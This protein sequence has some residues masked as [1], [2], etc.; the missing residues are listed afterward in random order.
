[1]DEGGEETLAAEENCRMNY[2]VFQKIPYDALAGLEWD[3]G[4]EEIGALS[5]LQHY[6]L[7]DIHEVE[8]NQV[9][10]YGG[11]EDG[12]SWVFQCPDANDLDVVL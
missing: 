10:P 11:G 12:C 5:Q 4:D 1:M 6:D 2:F 9:Q 7:K 3:K 8:Q